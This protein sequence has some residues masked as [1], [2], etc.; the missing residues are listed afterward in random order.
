MDMYKLKWTRLQFEIFRFLCIR[1][2]QKINMRGL[3]KAL[4]VSPTAI[5]K[6]LDDLEKESFILIDRSKTMNLFLI[7]LNRDNTMVRDLKKIENLKILYES[8]LVSKLHN[9]FEGCAVILFGSYSRGED[10]VL[11]DIDIAVVG[12][13]ETTI[14]LVSYEKLLERKIIINYYTCWKEINKHLKDNILNGIVLSG[15]VDL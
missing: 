13:K 5:S 8:E 12:S 9:T 15:V 7:E 4:H 2:G 6:S 3:A 11:S 1:S 14:N 10:T